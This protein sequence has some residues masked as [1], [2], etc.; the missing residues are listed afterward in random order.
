MSKHTSA[1]RVDRVDLS[2]PIVCTE[3]PCDSYLR[4]R[5]HEAPGHDGPGLRHIPGVVTLNLD[6]RLTASFAARI[7]G[8]TKQTF[9]YWR[10][11][12]KITTG[13]D[14]CYRLGDVLA[15][16]R[17]MRNNPNSRRGARRPVTGTGSWAE[18]DRKRAVESARTA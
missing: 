4:V 17:D 15:V 16:E 2:R 18:R 5:H 12:G 14:G 11:S 10:T 3:D 1:C 9:N 13:E 6:A 7:A 8:V